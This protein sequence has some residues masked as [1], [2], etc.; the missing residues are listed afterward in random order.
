MPRDLETIVLRALDKDKRRR[1]PSA[2][3]F[4]RDLER[5]LHGEEIEAK[6]LSIAGQVSRTVRRKRLAWLAGAAAL[7]AA[8][9][10]AWLVGRS[11]SPDVSPIL[12]SAD[13]KLAS[14]DLDGAVTEYQAAETLLPG[15][16]GKQLRAALDRRAAREAEAARARKAA[17]EKAGGRER[18]RNT[19]QPEHD[20]GQALVDKARLDLYRSGADLSRMRETLEEAVRHFTKALEI[21]PAYPEALFGRGQ[22][23][24]LQHRPVDAIADLGRA[25]EIFPGYPAALLARGQI[26]LDRYMA[27]IL[28]TGWRREDAPE[29]VRR[30]IEQAIDDLKKAREGGLKGGDLEYCDASLA[31]AEDRPQ[32]A[33]SILTRTIDGGAP[34]EEFFKLRGDANTLLFKKATGTETQLDFANRAL[35]DYTEAIRMR[36]NYHEAYRSRAALFFS[37]GRLDPCLADLKWGIQMDP[38]ASTA[39]SDL[40]TYFQHTRRPEEALNCYARALELDPE[41]IRALSN[42]AAI[43]TERRDYPGA[44]AD[45]ESALKVNPDSIPATLNLSA[46]LDFQGDTEAAVGLLSKVLARQP[47]LARG[48]YMRGVYQN[49]LKRWA[50]ALDDLEKAAGIEPREFEASTAPLV[51]ELR[52]RLGK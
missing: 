49:K 27:Y 13:A 9:L 32:Q 43:K 50:E 2:E 16:S 6:R 11:S 52:K 45:L 19:A 37:V 20:A 38:A 44:R 30:W 51:A 8:A 3:A 18:A 23:R 22:A 39:H 21:F 15:S 4:A 5:F 12:A 17:A 34:K 14:G 36:A 7:V 46:V 47:M 42:R 35:R 25:L 28:P 10:G 26:L 33:A 1:Y 24:A 31:F 40:G 29:T 41:N 48:Y